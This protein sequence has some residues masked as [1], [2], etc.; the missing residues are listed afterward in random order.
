MSFRFTL[1][2]EAILNSMILIY[3]KVGN[4]LSI[5]QCL[6]FPEFFQSRWHPSH[7]NSSAK[8]GPWQ[9]W[10]PIKFIALTVV[11]EFI[12]YTCIILHNTDCFCHRPCVGYRKWPVETNVI[13]TVL[14]LPRGQQPWVTGPPHLMDVIRSSDFE[15]YSYLLHACM[16]CMIT[17]MHAYRYMRG[18]YPVGADFH[19][20]EWS[21]ASN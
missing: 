18:V 6:V 9:A 14:R 1:F 16:E 11:G 4:G 3:S 8:Y 19:N 21:P 2:K 10:Q 7:T 17:A 5:P 20:I 12:V 13:L 15:M